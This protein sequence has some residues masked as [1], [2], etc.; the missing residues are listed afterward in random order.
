MWNTFGYLD[1][2]NS[3]CTYE[4]ESHFHNTECPGRFCSL[5][6]TSCEPW[7]SEVGK[8][9]L[10]GMNK[11]QASWT[12]IIALQDILK[13]F[14]YKSELLR[15]HSCVL[16]GE[17]PEAPAWSRGCTVGT[18]GMLLWYL[19]LPQ[20]G[21]NL[22]S[23]PLSRGWGRESECAEPQFCRDLPSCLWGADL[24]L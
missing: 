17:T 13:V 21:Q 22:D 24:S 20:A 6:K 12:V 4:Q 19:T 1:V 18:A 16:S 5:R 2:W 10:N 11:W 3:W 9:C 23:F 15:I 8:E 14:I 7:I